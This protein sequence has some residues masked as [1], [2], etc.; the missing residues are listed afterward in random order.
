MILVNHHRGCCGTNPTRPD[1]T[2]W[3]HVLIMHDGA[4]VRADTPGEVLTMLIPGYQD[5]DQ[6]GRLA[7]RIGHAE[8]MALDLQEIHHHRSGVSGDGLETVVKAPR[9]LPMTLTDPA[10]P[11]APARW[12]A[13]MPLV[14]VTT[15]YAPHTDAPRIEGNVVW[16]DP[17]EE[18]AFLD[19]LGDARVYDYWRD[20]SAELPAPPQG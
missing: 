5:L 9:S 8:Q 6:E 10:R 16:I 12:D 3:A 19:S 2:E 17:T 13:P 7:A 11:D 1:G 15:T 18:Q 14:L 20:R 4:D